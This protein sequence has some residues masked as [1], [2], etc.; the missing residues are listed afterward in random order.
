MTSTP[1]PAATRPLVVFALD[2]QRFALELAVVERVVRMVAI[3]PL[4]RAPAIILGVFSLHGEI[5]PVVNVRQRFR[6]PPRAPQTGDH[7]LVARTPRRRVALP[8]DAVD[9]V[10]DV[11]AEAIIDP[12][13][14][15]PGLQ[16]VRGIARLDAAG[17]VFIHDLDSFL[18]LDEEAAL[19]SALQEP[20]P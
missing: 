13:T 18:S 8:V 11:A 9:E 12:A 16:L 2:E 6:L 7:L 4:P 20:G 17:L 1:S 3:E 15:A 5:V 14:V 19:A 10:R